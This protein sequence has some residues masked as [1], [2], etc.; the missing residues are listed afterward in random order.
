MAILLIG[1]YYA[2]ERVPPIPE[3]V[4]QGQSELTSSAAILRGKATYQR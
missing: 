1:G 4:V 2:V 3:K